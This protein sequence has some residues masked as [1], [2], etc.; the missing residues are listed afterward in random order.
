MKQPPQSVRGRSARHHF[1]ASASPDKEATPSQKLS[2][3][4]PNKSV[5]VDKLQDINALNH[6]SGGK[7]GGVNVLFGDSHA[8]F[9][10]VKGNSAVGEPF[11]SS[12]WPAA[13]PLGNNPDAFRVVQSLFQP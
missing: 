3:I 8:K 7:A 4:D 5:C 9:V 2:L 1:S 13:T 11:Y 10:N 12:Y 6:K